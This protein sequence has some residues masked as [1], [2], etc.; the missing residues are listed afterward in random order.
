[1]EMKCKAVCTAIK[2]KSTSPAFK[3]IQIGDIFEFSTPIKRV[4][5]NR[6]TYATYITCL[7]TRTNDTS[8]LS[9]NQIARVL[10]NF[11]FEEY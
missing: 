11:E 1:M 5:R 7:N 2:K 8:E 6:G 10:E 4:G 3:N 9:F